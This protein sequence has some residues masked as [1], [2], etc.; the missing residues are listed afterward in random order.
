MQRDYDI[1]LSLHLIALKFVSYVPVHS[2]TNCI[3]ISQDR[4]AILLQ[5]FKNDFYTLPCFNSNRLKCFCFI[6]WKK[7]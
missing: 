1:I 6:H 5:R 7:K 4:L 2:H 3:N